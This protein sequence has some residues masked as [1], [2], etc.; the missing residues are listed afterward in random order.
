M[1]KLPEC[2]LV[3]GTGI[4]ARIQRRLC[5]HRCGNL[6]GCGKRR[7]EGWKDVPQRLKPGMAVQFTAQLK[8]CPSR[9]EFSCGP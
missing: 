9:A 5:I 7:G 4:A 2:L 1:A 3:A 6:A 8:P